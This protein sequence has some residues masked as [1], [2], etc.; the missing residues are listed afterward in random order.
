[1]SS[2]FTPSVNGLQGAPIDP[3]TYFFVLRNFHFYY[4]IIIKIHFGHC[5][6]NRVVSREIV[7]LFPGESLGIP[8]KNMYYQ[9]QTY[10]GYKLK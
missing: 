10:D 1:M 3:G 2:V 7:I 4:M 5:V 8:K 9:R 6:G